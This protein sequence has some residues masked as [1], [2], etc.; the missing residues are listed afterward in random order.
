MFDRIVVVGRNEVNR[1][2]FWVF[3]LFRQAML[4]IIHLVKRLKCKTDDDNKCKD[5]ISLS[6]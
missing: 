4:S 3:I 1:M 6:L 5:D 2:M